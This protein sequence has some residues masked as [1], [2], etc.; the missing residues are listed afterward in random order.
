MEESQAPSVSIAAPDGGT[1]FARNDTISFNG[2]AE[3]PEEGAL[4]GDALTWESSADGTFGTGEQV[5]TNALSPARHTITLIATDESGTTGRDSIS[6]AVNGPPT[7]DISAP[8]DESGVDEGAVTLDGSGTDPVDG[9]VSTDRLE[10]SSDVD[11]ALGTGERLSPGLSA[12]P[13]TITLTVTDDDGNTASASSDIVVEQPGFNIRLRFASDFTSDQKQTI[14]EALAPWEEAITG[15]LDPLFPPLDRAGEC[16]IDGRGIDDLVL[17][18]QANPLDGAGGVL[19]QAGPCVV[20]TPAAGLFTTPASGVVTID[21]AD[22]DNPDLKQ[23]VTHEV[24]HALGIGIGPIEGWGSNTE[25]LG[26]LDPLHAGTNTVDA[27]EQLESDAYLSDGVPLENVGGQGT[28][29]GHWR[30]ANFDTELMTGFINPNIEMPLS[31]VSLAALED[32]G[33]EVDRSAADPFELPMPQ[34]TIWQPVADATVS[35]P[36]SSDENFGTPN[37]TRLDTTLVAG[38]NNNELWSTDPEGE[39]FSSLVR[40][41]VPSSVPMGVTVNEAAVRLVVT[42]RNAETSDHNV[43]LFPVDAEWS[44]GAVTGNTRPAVRDSVGRFDFESCEEC[45]LELTDLALDWL[46]GNAENHGV[47]LRAPDARSDSTFSVGFFSR[48]VQSPFQRPLVVVSA[49]TEPSPAAA[50][51]QARQ[52]ERPA[53]EKIPLGNDIRTGPLI[54]VDADGNVVWTDRLR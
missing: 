29:G 46:N 22:L 24:G 1:E 35:R 17:A 43:A 12:G 30:E 18:V 42:D 54:G 13:H 51:A 5:T 34:Q 20:R 27:F 15:D 37:G 16:L 38:S 4:T 26:T 50:R 19:A 36:A 28:A 14:R 7:V 11:G 31:R 2:S 9:A 53:G 41:D 52:V 8:E 40:F 23:I 49:E 32:I 3:D 6:V 45:T 47:S 25:D 10:W 39:I 33:Y 44:E 48:H 21:E